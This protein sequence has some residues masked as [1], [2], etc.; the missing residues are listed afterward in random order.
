M[1]SLSCGVSTA[2]LTISRKFKNWDFG[3]CRPFL[4]SGGSATGLSATDAHWCLP[5]VV[6][7]YAEAGG[8]N[9]RAGL[10][11]VALHSFTPTGPAGALAPRCIGAGTARA[12]F[13]CCG[14]IR[15]TSCLRLLRNPHPIT[16]LKQRQRVLDRLLAFYDLFSRVSFP[17]AELL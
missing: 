4:W 11:A 14:V 9:A 3:M 12:R 1:S 2:D 6:K 10:R 13:L 15:P 16:A 7:A 8:R 5:V 17:A